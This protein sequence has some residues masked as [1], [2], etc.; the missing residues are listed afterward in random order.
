[1]P[2]EVF[3]NFVDAAAVPNEELVEDRAD[4]PLFMFLWLLFLVPSEVI[5]RC[6]GTVTGSVCAWLCVICCSSDCAGPSESVGSVSV[7]CKRGR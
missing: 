5:D 3:S 7:V 1:M 4:T 6:K 2:F